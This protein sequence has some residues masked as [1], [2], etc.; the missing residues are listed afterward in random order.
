MEKANTLIKLYRFASC[1]EAVTTDSYDYCG[2][3]LHSCCKGRLRLR[4]TC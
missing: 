3:C 2:V 1:Y 4:S